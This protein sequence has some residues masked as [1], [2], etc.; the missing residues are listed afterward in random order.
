MKA[1]VRSYAYWS[2]VDSAII[3][4]VG[5]CEQ[6]ALAAKVL[7]RCEL[8]T[9][10]APSEPMKS[11]KVECA[12]PTKNRHVLFVVDTYSKWPEKMSVTQGSTFATIVELD[13]LFSYFT[14]P[15]AVVTGS[16]IPFN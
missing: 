4:L 13:R 11:T 5:G 12:V 16:G 8:Y 1:I 6:C 9:C 2:T 14:V 7:V 15:V 3:D 10:S